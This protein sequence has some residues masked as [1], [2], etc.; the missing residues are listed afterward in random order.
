MAN[1]SLGGGTNKVES[2]TSSFRR[3]GRPYY[4]AQAA[5]IG[6]GDFVVLSS[7]GSNSAEIVVTDANTGGETR[8]PAGS[9]QA[10]VRATGGN[11][12]GS[13][14][15]KIT[16]RVIAV[17]HNPTRNSRARAA[18]HK[19]GETSVLFVDDDP[20]SIFEIECNAAITAT[21]MNLNANLDTGATV[22][23]HSGRS[24][25]KLD[26]SSAGASAD[27]QLT[28]LRVSEN[29]ARRDIAGT[30]PSCS[31]YVRINAHT[32]NDRQAGV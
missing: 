10:V 24:N 6:I 28:I 22:S 27:K 31:V 7:D 13:G 1:A 14:G 19:S 3:N 11:D 8:Y 2:Y 20:A 30:S 29:V 26:V 17:D 18:Y 12:I 25:V 9:L 4:C 15:S 21:Q 16:G 5:D 23:A 32:E